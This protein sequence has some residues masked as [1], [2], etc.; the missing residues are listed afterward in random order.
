MRFAVFLRYGFARRW[1]A[2]RLARKFGMP[3][4]FV[5]RSNGAQFA[6]RTTL[7]SPRHLSP[8]HRTTL[9]AGTA[10]TGAFIAAMMGSPQSALA[11]CTGINSGSVTC[12][13]GSEAA[14]GTLNTTFNGTT[15][16]NVNA[17]GKIDTG[18]AIAT[19]TGPGTRTLTSP[20]ND[21]T[22]GITNTGGTAV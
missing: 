4:R 11:A 1:T 3:S 14:A 19:G 15:V 20:H 21:T 16:V 18:G 2:G 10:F 12:E 22:C 8:R 13:T 17:G 6:E 7:L 5:R 9:L